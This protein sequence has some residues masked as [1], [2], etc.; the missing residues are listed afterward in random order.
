VALR[1]QDDGIGFVV[2]AASPLGD[3]E[4]SIGLASMQERARLL[5]GEVRINSRPGHGT[6][7]IATLPLTASAETPA[8]EVSRS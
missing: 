5:G 8:T 6:E 7:V 3:G 2:D 4:A 1:V